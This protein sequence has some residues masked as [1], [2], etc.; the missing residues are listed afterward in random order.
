[1]VGWDNIA[2]VHVS[3]SREEH[4]GKR[5]LHAGLVPDTRDKLMK[6]WDG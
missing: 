2:A 4:G 3:D 1:M 6:G 5:D